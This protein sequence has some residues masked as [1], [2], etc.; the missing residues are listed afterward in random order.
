MSNLLLVCHRYAP[1]PGGTEIYVHNIAKELLERGHEVTVLAQTHDPY[2]LDKG[3]FEGVKITNDHD[4]IFKQVFDLI[5]VHG[6][7]V[8]SQDYVHRNAHLIKSPVLYMII[9]PSTSDACMNGL[10]HH[11]YLGVSTIEDVEHVTRV[12]LNLNNKLV[13]IP[14]GIKVSDSIGIPVKF[15][16]EYLD[17]VSVGGFWPH[18][19]FLALALA[20]M[21]ISERPIT[22]CL[23]GY[24]CF[25]QAK[26]IGNLD[27]S[28]VHC[29]GGANRQEIM[30]AMASADLYV[31]NSTEEGF[32]LVLLEAMLNRVPWAARNIAGAKVLSE[33]GFVYD[34][35]EELVEYLKTFTPPSKETL[36]KRRN[37]VLKNYTIRNTVDCIERLI[38]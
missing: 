24:D 27:A 7:D 38:E 16:T 15:T 17:I 19:G 5:V 3:H 18:K 23:Y 2:H 6:G 28:H 13:K 30:N 31:M 9:K 20:V 33:H 35:E 8:Y 36:E 12:S 26:A 37:F 32:G 1:F 4:I 10:R 21:K 22:L 29:Y 11:T 25:D 34:T 14:H